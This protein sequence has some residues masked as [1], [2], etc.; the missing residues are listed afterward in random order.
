MTSIEG[1]GIDAADR[2]SLSVTVLEAALAE[3]RRDGPRPAVRVG[4]RPA[5]EEQLRDGVEAWYRALA[6]LTAKDGRR[7][8]LV[9]AANQ[10][11][12]WTLR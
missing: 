12:R 4:D 7:V 5:T 3:V 6:A 11:R 2:A 8:E 10:V 9:D 1:V